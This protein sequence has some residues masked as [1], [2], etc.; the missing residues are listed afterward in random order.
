MGFFLGIGGGTFFF[1]SGSL[2]SRF[3]IVFSKGG[4]PEDSGRLMACFSAES[5]VSFGSCKLSMDLL[6]L[7]I[8]GL[9]VAGRTRIS[10]SEGGAKSFSSSLTT[11]TGFEPAG[12]DVDVLITL[13]IGSVGVDAGVSGF[14][15]CFTRGEGTG[16]TSL[17]EHLME[18][19]E[20]TKEFFLGGSGHRTV[21][22][23]LADSFSTLKDSGVSDERMFVVSAGGASSVT[24]VIASVTC[25]PVVEN[26]DKGGVTGGSS[27][28]GS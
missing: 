15:E 8:V 28:D 7:I 16:E 14:D 5:A 9:T 3:W 12:V 11:G 17:E 13:E 27:D 6:A 23:V 22:S 25:S 26:E 2:R 4:F 24:D 10:V 19:C 18:D 1:V 21:S 20:I